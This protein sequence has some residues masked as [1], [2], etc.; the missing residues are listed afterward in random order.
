[1]AGLALSVLDAARDAGVA[2]DDVLAAHGFDVT[3]LTRSDAY[4]PVALHE[5]LWAEGARRS[6]MTHFGIYAAGRITPGL[7]GV[8]EYILRNCATV[9]DAAATWIR[10]A[11]VVSDRIEGA[12]VDAGPWLR[13]EWRLTRPLSAGATQW[14]VFAQARALRLMRD[15]LS[16]ETLAPEEVWFRHEAPPEV[17]A[18]EAYFRAPV[19]F[20]RPTAALVWDRAL[21]DRALRWVDPVARA[22][23]EVRAEALRESLRHDA[24]DVVAQV[25][26]A[27]VEL[28]AERERDLRLEVVAARVRVPPRTLQARLEAQGA[29]F[30]ALAAAVKAE[31]ARQMLDEQGLTTAEAA[32]RLGFADASS[33]RKARRRWQRAQGPRGLKR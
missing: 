2:L 17:G 5:A 12:L 23:L 7:T 1:M 28:L 27:L 25:R 22:A 4:V 8:V 10:F 3:L 21:R 32:R 11:S 26:A 6:G 24:P 15:V 31:A 9:G 20:G 29:S 14:S 16:E 13:L 33:L 19:R 30:R 18:L